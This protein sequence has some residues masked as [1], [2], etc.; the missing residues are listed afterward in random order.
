MQARGSRVKALLAHP[1]GSATNLQVTT[2]ERGGLLRSRLAAAA[3][4]G[5]KRVAMSAEDGAVGMLRCMAQPGL[6]RR[7]HPWGRPSSRRVWSL[8]GLSRYCTGEPTTRTRACMRAWRRLSCRLMSLII[9]SRPL[10]G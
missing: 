9:A 4:W 8:V 1:G 2:M 10:R 6:V 3:L 7:T 5:F